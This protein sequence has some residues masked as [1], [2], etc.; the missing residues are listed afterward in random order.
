MILNP[1][2]TLTHHRQVKDNFII[3]QKLSTLEIFSV[4]VWA[5]DNIQNF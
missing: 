4:A 5:T 1:L 3:L 2:L